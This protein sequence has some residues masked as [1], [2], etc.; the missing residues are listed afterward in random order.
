MPP[1]RPDTRSVMTR[2]V[3]RRTRSLLIGASLASLAAVGDH[4]DTCQSQQ[5]PDQGRAGRGEHREH[6]AG[7]ERGAHRVLLAHA[8][9]YYEGTPRGIDVNE[10]DPPSYADFGYL[11]LTIGMTLSGL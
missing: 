2:P 4:P 6:R 11:A 5:R 1:G 10:S 8:R 7:V 3:P 9:L